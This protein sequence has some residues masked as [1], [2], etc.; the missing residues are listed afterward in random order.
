MRPSKSFEPRI[1]AETHRPLARDPATF[2]SSYLRSAANLTGAPTIESRPSTWSRR[3]RGLHYGAPALPALVYAHKKMSRKH[4]LDIFHAALE[5]ADPI[6]AVLALVKCDGKEGRGVLRVDKRS[7]RLADYDRIYVIGSG[8]A[9]AKMAQ[10]LE[11]LL[12]KRI[13]GGWIN[14]PDGTK[15]KLKRI[16]LHESGHPVPDERG[17]EGARRIAEIA[18]DAGPRDLLLCVIS[19]G[20]S[21]L[22]PLPVEG[23]TLE[24]KKA[25]TRQL[26][27]CGATIHE[28]NTVRKHLSAIKGGHL[29]ALAAPAT[30]VALILSDVIGDDLS[31]IGSGPT[32]L[33]STTVDDAA[34]VLKRFGIAVPPLTETPKTAK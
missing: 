6:Q 28:M 20:A 30:V 27:A 34:A 29:A 22:M 21:A 1:A 10:A 3:R 5:A 31:V 32:V 17:V 25:V 11:R 18:R 7:Y 2:P 23:M 14:V 16:H 13:T 9:S 8:K 15:A 4:A 24:G 12:G 26:L 19:G 33:D